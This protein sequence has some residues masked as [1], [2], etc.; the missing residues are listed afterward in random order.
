MD[1]ENSQFMKFLFQIHRY[2]QFPQNG[3]EP[4]W[5]TNKKQEIINS[6]L[7]FGDVLKTS[8]WE[9]LLKMNDSEI[10]V[11]ML[12]SKSVPE[13]CVMEIIKRAKTDDIALN[14]L[15]NQDLGNMKAMRII[16]EL[17]KRMQLSKI[18]DFICFYTKNYNLVT[19]GTLSA[20][21]EVVIDKA[22]WVTSCT[23]IFRFV[24]ST[25]PVRE[26]LKE[27]CGEKIMTQIVNNPHIPTELRIQAFQ[28][29]VVIEALDISVMPEEISTDVYKSIIDAKLEFN[30]EDDA[31]NGI[32]TRM[33][34][35]MMEMGKL[36]SACEYDL[37]LRYINKNIKTKDELISTF[38][39][40]SKNKDALVLATKLKGVNKDAIYR[41]PN[42]PREKVL[43][44][45]IKDIDDIRKG[46]YAQKQ[47]YE[48][49]FFIN[50]KTLSEDIYKALINDIKSETLIRAIINSDYTPD[51]I[52]QKL[53]DS[54][55]HNCKAMAI[56]SWMMRN[57]TLKIRLT[58]I[59]QKRV[60]ATIENIMNAYS[61]NPQI[62]NNKQLLLQKA[63]YM[64][65]DVNDKETIK[66]Y[67]KFIDN[68]AE[69]PFINKGVLMQYKKIMIEELSE[70]QPIQQTEMGKL[71]DE[72]QN[73]IQGILHTGRSDAYAK[74]TI[75]KNIEKKAPE[76]E[77]LA[78]RLEEI[79]EEKS[80]ETR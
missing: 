74:Y 22:P 7:K 70:K 76:Y 1:Y 5:F 48:L 8:D 78:N 49:E 2:S 47:F 53:A 25:S 63:S 50:S 6:I 59:E 43:S 54:Y 21:A 56:A 41:N 12:H 3:I 15:L 68:V 55:N 51:D 16:N 67:C 62:I 57:S 73:I 66:E 71:I 69:H 23:E 40:T 32:T 45:A 60:V 44:K 38:A 30:N 13:Q 58:D 10:D 14:A 79:K 65:N 18:V 17:E 9:R 20:C 33:L 35:R 52:L 24:K 27:E 4:T 29:G 34:Q 61:R 28:Q 11:A 46:K 42:L 64:P 37:I 26:A 19:A 31:L 75:F 80:F 77:I 72:M 39:S 36:P